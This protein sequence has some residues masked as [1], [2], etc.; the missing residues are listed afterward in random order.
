RVLLQGLTI[1]GD[2]LSPAIVTLNDPGVI[3]IESCTVNGGTMTGGPGLVAISVNSCPSVVIERCVMTGG[4]ATTGGS[5]NM[6]GPALHGARSG[7]AVSASQGFG[8][9]GAPTAMA[10]GGFGGS[11]LRVLPGSLSAF[12]S[13]SSF[14]GGA[15]ASPVPPTFPGGVG[16]A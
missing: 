13:G 16:G 7:A 5:T 1:H 3:W 15:G 12:A 8:G 9:V 2:D 4:N 11:G 6:G 14:Q 10:G